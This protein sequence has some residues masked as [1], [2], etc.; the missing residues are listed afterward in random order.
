[1]KRLKSERFVRDSLDVPHIYDLRDGL[2]KALM[3]IRGSVLYYM[4]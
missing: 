3:D 4:S 1:M 2:N